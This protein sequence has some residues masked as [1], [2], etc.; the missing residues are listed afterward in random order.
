MAKGPDHYPVLDAAR[1]V[2]ALIVF[3]YHL[4]EFVYPHLS[5]GSSGL[6]IKS[7]L[8]VD[9]FFLMS[10]LVIARSYAEKLTDGSMTFRGFVMTRLIRLYP[11][12]ILG[13]F[14]GLGY[15]VFRDVITGE[16]P[17]NWGDI[18]RSLGLNSLFVPDF[19]NKN[20]IFVLDPAAWSL[21]LEWGIN[22]VYA[23][24]AVR[25]S[26]KIL[27]SVLAVSAAGLAGYGMSV[28][29]LDLGWAGENFFGG[30][31]RIC[32]SFTLGVLIFRMISQQKKDAYKI[33]T[34]ILAAALLVV[35]AFFLLF[36]MLSDSVYDDFL[37]VFL[38]FPFCV[39]GACFSSVS[40][41][42]K[43]FFGMLGDMSYA[44]YILHTPLIL[45]VAGG[46]KFIMK[47]EPE[48]HGVSS[49]LFIII[50]VIGLSYFATRYIDTPVR[51]YLKKK[52]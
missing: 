5:I 47:S 10:G 46:W 35:M 25:F 51:R 43:N 30:G 49:A 40:G 17:E 29:T 9:L 26:T 6:L 21:A 19:W 24:W 39:Y 41:R 23:A 45:W 22:L 38:V 28:G 7:Y 52:I 32:F 37:C 1:G 16:S 27:M 3:L 2:A 34:K 15:L 50:S 31:L 8:A 11:L 36:P 14:A 48:T 4:K 33:Q 13:I 42:W 44:M 12:Y 18:I 20:G